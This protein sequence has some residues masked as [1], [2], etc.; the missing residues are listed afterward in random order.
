MFLERKIKAETKNVW[1]KRK[2]GVKEITE[3]EKRRE[4][5]K[6]GKSKE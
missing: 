6:K 3:K 4:K 1:I 2:E 5:E